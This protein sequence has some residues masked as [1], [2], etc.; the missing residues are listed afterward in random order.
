MERISI[1]RPD[2]FIGLK[3][4][5]AICALDNG[6]VTLER[7]TVLDG[8]WRGISDAL[9]DSSRA[10]LDTAFN[11]SGDQSTSVDHTYQWPQFN[12]HHR[13]LNEFTF[14]SGIHPNPPTT[15]FY[16]LVKCYTFHL[17]EISGMIFEKGNVLLCV[18]GFGFMVTTIPR[19]VLVTSC[20]ECKWVKF[21][22]TTDCS[23]G[24]FINWMLR[25]VWDTSFSS[26]ISMLHVPPM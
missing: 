21:V 24:L 15:T 22:T 14:L 20:T 17:E 6:R 5:K 3:F 23:L 25:R 9:L 26:R 1:K 7:L 13:T 2:K 10:W 16:G 19:K 12:R 8:M 11:F 4:Q 18:N